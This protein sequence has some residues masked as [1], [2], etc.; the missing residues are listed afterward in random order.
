[1]TW[2]QGE[3]GVWQLVEHLT[4]PGERI[5]DPFA[6]TADWGRTAVAMGRRWIGADVVSGGAARAVV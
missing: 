6:G 5:V 4:D 3:A 2:Q 1:M